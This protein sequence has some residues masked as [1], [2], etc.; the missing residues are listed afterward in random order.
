MSAGELFER[1]IIS[2]NEARELF[3]L[4]GL[5]PTFS[6]FID[7]ESSRTELPVVRRRTC[8]YCGGATTGL[9][10]SNCGAPSR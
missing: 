4:P 3:G 8:E 9:K 10:C 6:V 1:G 5:D 2:R 7:P